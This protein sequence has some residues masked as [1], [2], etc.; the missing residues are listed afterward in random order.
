[1]DQRLKAALE[2][3]IERQS[4][5]NIIDAKRVDSAAISGDTATVILTPPVAGDADLDRLREDIEPAVTGI[6]GVDR[7]RIVMT[8]HKPEGKP[9]PQQRQS[10]PATPASKPARHVIAVASGKGG[11]GKS[12]VAANLAAALAKSGMKVGLLDA[13]IYGPSAP[14]LFGP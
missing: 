14:R 2:T 12:T 4:G 3:V 8:A 10:K 1:M 9:A 6:E 11:V 5:R 13:D 7:V